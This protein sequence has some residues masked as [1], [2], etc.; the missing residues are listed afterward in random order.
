MVDQNRTIQYLLNSTDKTVFTTQDLNKIWQYESYNSLIHRIQ[1]LNKTNKILKLKQGLY[2]FTGRPINQLEMAN[3][4]RT[5]SYI[6]FETALIQHGVIFQWDNKITLAS[7]QSVTLTVADTD[8]VFRQLKDH[9]LLNQQGIIKQS[10]YFIAG[11]ERAILDILYINSSFTFDNLRAVD[12]D[13]ARQ[14]L[15]MYQTSSL[16]A[17]LN[18]LEHYAKSQ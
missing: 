11:L 18:K 17:V 5:P 14:L 9:I 10:N 16:T 8:I 3:K 1:Y 7:N 15:P 13:K 4:L 6:S 12:F 2:S